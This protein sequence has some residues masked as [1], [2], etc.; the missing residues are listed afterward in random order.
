MGCGVDGAVVMAYTARCV[1]S[2]AASDGCLPCFLCCR[3]GLA[4]VIAVN[5]HGESLSMAAP[6]CSRQRSSGGGSGHQLPA[7]RPLPDADPCQL[8]TAA[9]RGG[10]CAVG[11]G[12]DA[13]AIH[14]T[15]RAQR[16]H[17]VGLGRRCV[18]PGGRRAALSLQG[19]LTD[20]GEQGRRITALTTNARCTHWHRQD[21]V[22]A[23]CQQQQR[24][25]RLAAAAAS[26]LWHVTRTMCGRMWPLQLPR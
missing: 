16:R 22:R 12:V 9:G 25:S 1:C 23:L 26:D 10:V 7:R 2:A 14:C 15:E 18:R 11:G 6:A 19:R 24:S 21:G 5:R 4:C 20:S 17:G 3:A 13:A 8:S